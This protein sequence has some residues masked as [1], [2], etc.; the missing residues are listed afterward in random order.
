MITINLSEKQAKE[1]CYALGWREYH[2]TNESKAFLPEDTAAY[3]FSQL[4]N[5]LYPAPTDAAEI[6]V[7]NH[8][9][10]HTDRKVEQW[11]RKNET[12]EET[13]E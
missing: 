13:F 3:M 8:E 12:A 11:K 6:A 2:G 5:Q 4:E 9:N 10:G 1:L 7:W